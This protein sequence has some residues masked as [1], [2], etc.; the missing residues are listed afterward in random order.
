MTVDNNREF[1]KNSKSEYAALDM[2]D[3][4]NQVTPA[5]RMRDGKVIADSR[6]VAKKFG[7]QHFNV[8]QS[9]RNLECSKNF[10]ELN[11][12]FFT[13]QDVSDPNYGKVSHVEMTR[14]GFSFL[15]MGFTGKDAAGWK[16]KYIDAFNRME[17]G[18]NAKPVIDFSDPS[19]LLGCFQSLQKQVA[20]KDAVIEGMLPKV[21]ALERIENADG[22]MCISNAAKTLKTERVNDLFKFMHARRWIFKR[23]GKGAWLA[24]QDKIRAGYM[25][26]RDH[27]Y[28]DKEDRER[29]STQ[30]FVTAK[31]LVKLAE[32]LNQP[33]H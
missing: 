33:M 15:V 32:L 19:I 6:D 11:F 16:E 21:E 13:I 3:V 28:I 1:S 10:I 4:D 26:H 24:H 23:E 9:I 25:E 8:L 29:V 5:L 2:Y 14:D 27:V 22:S 20:E 17:A 12:Q 30:A 31:G 7:K 18:L